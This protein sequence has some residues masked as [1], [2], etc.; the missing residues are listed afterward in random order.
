M[1]V[2]VLSRALSDIWILKGFTGQRDRR[3]R[4][5]ELV[6]HVPD[7]IVLDLGQFLLSEDGVDGIT[8]GQNDDQDQS[9]GAEEHD[10]HGLDQIAT[11]LG[12]ID[13][14]VLGGGE[15]VCRKKPDH[16]HVLSLILLQSF[17]VA[18]GRKLQG[19]S[20]TVEDP[21]TVIR[22]DPAFFQLHPQERIENNQIHPLPESFLKGRA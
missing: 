1:N 3:Y 8:K 21:E 20:E 5:L 4:G 18:F 2:I 7:Q 6:G 16:E 19:F 11:L 15:K 22:F 12:E 17:H 10:P 9:G 14:K 13:P